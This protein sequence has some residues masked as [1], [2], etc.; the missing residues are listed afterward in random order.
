MLRNDS[1][2]DLGSHWMIERKGIVS[3]LNPLHL[4]SF[5]INESQLLDLKEAYA[6][7]EFNSF[8]YRFIAK[9]NE[10]NYSHVTCI[11]ITRNSY[12]ENESLFLIHT[13]EVGKGLI[14]SHDSHSWI[15]V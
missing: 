11:S 4:M 9:I 2:N 10:G 12:E 6:W 3:Q 15:N 14:E 8:T 13:K 7:E 1:T 5:D